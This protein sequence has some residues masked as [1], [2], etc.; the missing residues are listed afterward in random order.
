[1]SRDRYYRKLIQSR[2]WRRLRVAT[3]LARPYCEDC[4]EKGKRIGATEVHH[5]MPVEPAL[6]ES[7]KQSLM[8]NPTNLRCLCRECHLRI[9]KEMRVHSKETVKER[10][11]Q[12]LESVLNSFFPGIKLEKPPRG[13][14]F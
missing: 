3:L 1:M 8:F 7:E 12:R 5:I 4:L 13:A 11:Q 6:S 2:R 14:F 9:H 10:Q